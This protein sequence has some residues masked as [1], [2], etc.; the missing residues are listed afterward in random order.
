MQN[1]K[2]NK[3]GGFNIFMCM[4]EVHVST[5]DQ[6][7]SMRPLTNHTCTSHRSV[8]DYG[9]FKLYLSVCLAFTS[10]ILVTTSQIY[11]K[12]GERQK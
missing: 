5:G 7:D 11:M 2:Q 8:G 1:F 10:Y 4:I 12:R 6:E 9:S 3:T